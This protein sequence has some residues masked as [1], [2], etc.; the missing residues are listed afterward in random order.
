MPY[1]CRVERGEVRMLRSGDRLYRVI[2][3]RDQQSL[4]VCATRSTGQ[5]RTLDIHRFTFDCDGVR[6]PWIE[7]A[8]ATSPVKPWRQQVSGGRM[9]LRFWAGGPIR[10]RQPPVTLPAGFAPTPASGLR[11]VAAETVA[12]AMEREL[13]PPPPPPQLIARALASPPPTKAAVQP[14]SAS[15][16]TSGS[17]GEIADPSDAIEPAPLSKL[18][19]VQPQLMGFGWTATVALANDT[20][21][22]GRWNLLPPGGTSNTLLAVLGLA[23]VLLSA[24]AVAARHRRIARGPVE[25]GSQAI[26]EDIAANRSLAEFASAPPPP[27]PLPRATRQLEPDEPPVQLTASLPV[28]PPPVPDQ[29]QSDWDAVVE[30]GTT[31]AALLEIVQQIIADNLPNG[32][33][34][35]VLEGEL[36]VTAAR[37]NGPE[38][39]LALD[40]GRLD[41]V[42]P[43]YTQAILDLER[44]R[45]LARIEHERLLEAGSGLPLAP[46]T[47]E[48]A[49][50]YLGVN[51]R[52]G[53]AVVKKVVDALRQNWHPDLAD[54]DEDR[55]MR[56]ERI[57]RINAA[58]DLIRAR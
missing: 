18:E 45:T 47:F 2:G 37:L 13:A 10:D 7:A 57:K 24:T 52:A 29:P 26:G 4:Q 38:L 46:A 21:G 41:L 53:E 55:A 33:L 54:D 44:V 16:R 56:E 3:P 22:A 8:E 27:P 34:R 39:T 11:F 17:G 58:W 14:R 32:P 43:V 49:C 9:T 5:C 30:M 19:L 25:I 23:A 6:I 12:P 1:A 20:A 50:N 40:E 28:G 51:P 42:H 31:A 15:A 35:E 36:I 48:E